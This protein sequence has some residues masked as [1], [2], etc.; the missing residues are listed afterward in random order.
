[1]QKSE[2]SEP[3]FLQHERP[4]F[5]PFQQQLSETSLHEPLAWRH[6][7]LQLPSYALPSY[8]R[9]D[10]HDVPQAWQ[11]SQVEELEPQTKIHTNDRQKKF[12]CP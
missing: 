12:Q 8:L 2:E 1:M 9:W 3:Q 11:R 6:G 10:D 5:F 4:S 7:E